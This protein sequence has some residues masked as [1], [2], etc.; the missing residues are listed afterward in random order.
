MARYDVETT[1]TADMMTVSGAVVESYMRFEV[2]ENTGATA[3]FQQS[4]PQL[5]VGKKL[6]TWRTA[7][8]TFLL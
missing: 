5:T 1:V 7:P 6:Y 2:N 3:W 4:Q 8:R